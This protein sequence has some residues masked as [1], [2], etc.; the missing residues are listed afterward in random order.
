M[1]NPN[2]TPKLI[3]SM[4]RHYENYVKW[5]D[6]IILSSKLDPPAT[7]ES[8]DQLIAQVQ[9]LYL[10]IEHAM[11]ETKCYAGYQYVGSTTSSG[12][13]PVDYADRTIVGSG[14][15]QYREWRR[16]YYTVS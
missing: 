8:P 16:R 1:A 7:K 9:G 6:N 2:K 11:R 5:T 13:E 12:A 10:M 3:V 4:I 14:D 15:D